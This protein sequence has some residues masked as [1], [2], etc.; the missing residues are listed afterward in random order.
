MGCGC[1]GEQG[2]FRSER[3]SADDDGLVGGELCVKFN[4][5][6]VFCEGG[7][8]S[9]SGELRRCVQGEGGERG[10]EELLAVGTLLLLGELAES[11]HALFNDGGWH[12][13]GCV[14]GPGAGVG[15]RGKREEMEIAARQGAEEA[16]G[17]GE[18]AIGLAGEAG[19]DVGSEGERGTGGAEERFDLLRVV[20]GA[21]AAVHAAEDGVGPGLERE[22]R[23]VGET[24]TPATRTRRWGPRLLA[25]ILGEQRDE[26]VVP[27]HG[28]NGA[29]AEEREI[30]FVEDL[31]DEAR[32]RGL[33]L[34]GLG[35]EIA[36]PTA[37][38][39]AGE[40]EF[41]APGGDEAAN[42]R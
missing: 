37:E 34:A 42:L 17:L 19:H 38:V 2:A 3:V 35:C 31:A 36:A 12:G 6:E 11:G 41:P 8:P 1:V 13:V 25:A 23:V 10:A 16:E 7:R 15:A 33:L 22:M 29:E 30:G 26:V 18:L 40:D 32:Q 20:P 24:T 21:I 28:L 39:D 5:E 14:Q 9:A 4:G 27:I